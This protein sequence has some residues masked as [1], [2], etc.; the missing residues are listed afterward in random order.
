MH[1]TTNYDLN[2]GKTQLSVFYRYNRSTNLVW[3]HQMDSHPL[4]LLQV[5]VMYQLQPSVRENLI[6]GIECDPQDQDKCLAWEGYQSFK[7]GNHC[8]FDMMRHY[9]IGRMG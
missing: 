4:G 3:F 7:L 1:G 9:K 5:V 6:K 2:N 8:I